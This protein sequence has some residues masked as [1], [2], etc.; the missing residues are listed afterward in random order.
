MGEALNPVDRNGNF[1]KKE[2]R[3]E[4]KRKRGGLLLF[5][6]SLWSTGKKKSNR[7]ARRVDCANGSRRGIGLRVAIRFDSIRFLWNVWG[8]PVWGVA[9]PFPT[10]SPP[11]PPR[12]ESATR[13]S[14]HGQRFD[15]ARHRIPSLSIFIE[16]G[17]MASSIEFGSMSV[18]ND[19]EEYKLRHKI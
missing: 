2:K 19:L 8:T 11:P 9:A 15:W 14:C 12:I 13:V 17:K 6:E 10:S 18:G 4:K 16:L 1:K 5:D 7:T 3:K